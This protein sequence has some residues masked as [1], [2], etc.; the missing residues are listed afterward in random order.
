M[1]TC[2]NYE[3]SG[4]KSFYG[5]I[6]INGSRLIQLGILPLHP[7]ERVNEGAAPPGA[8]ARLGSSAV[9]FLS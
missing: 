8:R 9:A 6:L 7:H 5:D 1:D 3:A 4:V 2:I